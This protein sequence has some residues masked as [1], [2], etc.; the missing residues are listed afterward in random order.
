MS[1][2][3][4]K[5]KQKVIAIIIYTT[6]CKAEGGGGGGNSNYTYERKEACVHFDRLHATFCSL[7]ANA[8]IICNRKY[9]LPSEQDL[10]HEISRIRSNVNA[11]HRMLSEMKPDPTCEYTLECDFFLQWFIKDLALL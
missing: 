7:Y 3:L 6:D 10:Q 2:Y 11:F 4:Q 5:E 9:Y 1:G 8:A